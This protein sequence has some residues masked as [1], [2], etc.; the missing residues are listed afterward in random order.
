MKIKPEIM[1]LKNQDINYQN[2]LITGLDESF[3]NY[4]TSFVIQKFKNKDFHI[5][6]SGEI[7]E[8]LTG[9]LF[10][11]NRVLFV[12]KKHPIEK[13]KVT[14]LSN[15]ENVMLISCL[16]NKNTNQKK[17]IFL[18]SENMLLLECYTLDRTSKSEV[19]KTFVEDKNI[20][21][22]NNI[23]WY[24]V[25]NLDNSFVFLKNQLEIL[26]L[27]KDKA[28]SLEAI[29]RAL[30]IENKIE[31]S[32][33]IFHIFKKNTILIN[34]FKKNIYSPQ[35]FYILLS[36]YKKYL[37]I[38]SNSSTKQ[39][40]LYKFPKYLFNEKKIFMKI[41]DQLNDVKL[42]KIHKNI[43]KVE[44]LIRQNSGLYYEVGLRFLINT[45][46]IIIS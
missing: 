21:I 1:L 45:K 6:T 46:K 20:E 10:S 35:D 7:N 13:E 42:I 22:S 43:F 16:N 44:K 28:N 36:F 14:I 32:K 12:L 17:S 26:S 23:F 24:L 30:T 8:N 4:V 5:D 38:I 18:K 27:M 15:K 37:E 40:A 41:Y 34:I 11:S 9:Q 29:E 39:E 25:D 33:I 3:I 2:I 31:I 19:I